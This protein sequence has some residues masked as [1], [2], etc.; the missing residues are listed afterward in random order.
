MRVV[1]AMEGALVAR[2]VQTAAVGRVV[3]MAALGA[4]VVACWAG[5]EEGDPAAMEVKEVMVAWVGEA[6]V[7]VVKGVL[8]VGQVVAVVVTEVKAANQ[9][10]EKA[11]VGTAV[12][13]V[14]VADLEEAA[15]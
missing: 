4:L 3:V 8:R 5:K 9:A 11:V 13:L 6:R 14:E 10:V 7:V 12:V 15:G 2:A 1:V